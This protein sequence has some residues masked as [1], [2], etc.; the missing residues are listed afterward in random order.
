MNRRCAAGYV[1]LLV[2]LAP[3][4]AHAQ[5]VSVDMGAAGQAGATG[6][7]V[8]LTALVAVLSSRPGCW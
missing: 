5:S 1:L 2:L 8:Q 4:A 3:F 7:L 6:R